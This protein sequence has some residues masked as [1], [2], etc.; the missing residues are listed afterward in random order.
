MPISPT[1][2]KGEAF[3]REAFRAPTSE[4]PPLGQL[5][6]LPREKE[7]DPIWANPHVLRIENLKFPTL[8]AQAALALF[9][10]K[11]SKML[12][13]KIGVGAE[14]MI[15]QWYEII[16]NSLPKFVDQ[17]AEDIFN[18]FKELRVL[19]IIPKGEELKEDDINILIQN[20][21]LNIFLSKY[22]ATIREI[23]N[24]KIK[25]GALKVAERIAL[26]GSNDYVADITLRDV[27][28]AYID[29]NRT[30]EAER[31]ALKISDNPIL[32]DIVKAF[33]KVGNLNTAERIALTIR[34][35]F[36]NGINYK[37]FSLADIVK[38]YIAINNL[39]EAER[40]ALS[41][42]KGETQL[43]A[44]LRIV[45]A[46]IANDNLSK[47]KRFVQIITNSI[48]T[49]SFESKSLLRDIV[50]DFIRTGNFKAAERL[51]LRISD[52]RFLADII[53]DFIRAG[54]FK[55]AKRIALTIRGKFILIGMNYKRFSLE[56]MVNA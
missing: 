21:V 27:I 29:A 32:G 34:D 49:S 48:T 33:I 53:K 35:G 20:A 8:Q 23:V 28:K 56:N 7:I 18:E 16:T 30:R 54:N 10:S 25:G 51:A 12:L 50:K 5:R 46:Y 15:R 36:I 43:L 41:L 37:R 40:V 26:L 45:K 2:P 24:Y 19:T 11:P 4:I 6:I 22:P 42:T 39:Q 31:L 52:L 3:L 14:I 17:N 38:A 55:A 1:H 44:L 47:A 13:V 9:G